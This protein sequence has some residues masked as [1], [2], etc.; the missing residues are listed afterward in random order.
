MAA[1]V[2]GRA[3]CVPK[4]GD[5]TSRGE[6]AA[7]DVDLDTALLANRLSGLGT[8]V[9]SVAHEINN[10]IT[11]VLGN[12]AELERLSGPL[13]DALAAYRAG[14]ETHV[15]SRAHEAAALAAEAKL[16][17]AGGI[18]QIDELVSDAIT[19]A[20][21]IR[22]LVRDL[23]AFGRPEAPQ[24]TRIDVHGTLDF[25]LRMT[26]QQARG[27]AAVTRDFRAT[28]WIMGDVTRLGQ[29]FL[30]LVRN[31][32]EACSPP[33]PDRHTIIV[34]TRDVEDGIEVEIEDTGVGIPAAV[35]ERIYTPFCTSRAGQGGTGLGLFL[36]R[37]IVDDHGGSLRF[38]D[39]KGGGTVF[40]VALPEVPTERGT[41]DATDCA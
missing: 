35:R 22:D 33:D 31:A 37:Q 36:C 41:H 20:L 28:R 29:V 5:S 16:A 11:Y 21:R 32:L 12:L 4:D 13:R 14:L 34:R 3:K 25:T 26:S 40:R 6:R 24:R 1:S 7:R 19:G 38:G 8:L 17:E 30:N 27:R 10:P 2:S 15:G 23:L 39:R 18:E 9:A